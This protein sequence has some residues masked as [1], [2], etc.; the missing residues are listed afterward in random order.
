MSC[1]AQLAA[2]LS[3][4]FLSGPSSNS[5]GGPTADNNMQFMRTPFDVGLDDVFWAL[6]IYR[7]L[8]SLLS[9]VTE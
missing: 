1:A 5:V 8:S 9:C 6:S 2:Q 3:K 7:G 4:H